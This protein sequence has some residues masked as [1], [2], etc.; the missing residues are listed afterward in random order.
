MKRIINNAIFIKI[1]ENMDYR[2]KLDKIILNFFGLDTNIETE[3]ING[4][5]VNLLE[6]I[7]MINKEQILK[8]IVKDTK[9]LFTTSKKI[10]INFS[11]I[12]KG[13]YHELL[14]PCYWEIYCP[15]ALKYLKNKPSLLL[16]AAFLACNNLQDVQK[17]LRRLKVFSKKEIED[18][19]KKVENQK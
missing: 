6:F 14:M 19:L 18:I 8:I 7:V 16:L 4:E 15:Y 1:F 13:K 10:Y 3:L 5:T 2:R 9:K 11:F 12:N 17:I